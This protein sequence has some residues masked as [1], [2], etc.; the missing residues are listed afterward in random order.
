MYHS[1]KIIFLKRGEDFLLIYNIAFFEFII[2]VRL[3]IGYVFKITGVCQFVGIHNQ[4]I[5][6]FFY[7]T[8]YNVRAY[9]TSSACD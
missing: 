1:V 5:G 6:I 9:K 4:I 3:D 7:K 2:G 8:P